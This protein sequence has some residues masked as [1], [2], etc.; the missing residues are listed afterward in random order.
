[1]TH[2]IVNARI[3]YHNTPV[4]I[5]ERFMMRDVA[6]AY[7]SFLEGG[8]EEC[9]I[10]QTCNRVEL[11]ARATDG[12]YSGM[13]R[14]WAGLA[15]LDPGEFE[16]TMETGED[17]EAIRHLL[18]L[19]AGLDSMVVGEE[20]VLGQI[21]NAIAS[22]KREGAAGTH[23]SA[24]FERAVRAGAKIRHSTGIGRGGVSVGS[25]AVK[26]AEENIDNM[27]SRRILIIG[28]GEVS[29]LVAKSLARRGY[30]FSVA[31]RTLRRAAAF[32]E[33]VGGEPIPFEDV[34]DGF[35]RYDVS[36]VATTAPYF[37]VAYDAISSMPRR[38]TGMMILDLSNP[39]AVDERIAT[40]P[41]IKLMNLDQIG[42]MVERHMRE[43]AVRAKAVEEMVQGE[44]PALEAAMHRLDAEPFVRD[45]YIRMD[46]IRADE[47]SRALR[48][49][50]ESDPRTIR[51][52]TDMSRAILEGI[53]SVPMGGIRRASQQGDQNVLGA[54]ARLF[55]YG[56]DPSGDHSA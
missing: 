18:R 13:V 11:F 45:V 36:F 44:V 1:M 5:L 52:M 28:T 4:H 22:A 15:G 38:D 34:L 21:R 39:R 53:A 55:D 46:K 9:V 49:M 40:I 27:K 25:M 54:A 56:K 17:S 8:L 24:L 51:I 50:G 14:V 20:Q 41:G 10:V 16:G 6:A 43:R 19:A 32:C 23:M 47:L 31:S 2:H 33:A 12:N 26:L 29:T 3:T 42:E 35:H 37:L 48:M 7:R 30:G